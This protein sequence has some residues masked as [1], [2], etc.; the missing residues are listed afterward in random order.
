MPSKRALWIA[1]IG[2]GLVLSGASRMQAGQRHANQ[3]KDQVIVLPDED[4]DFDVNVADLG[5]VDVDPVVVRFG[6]DGGRGYLG[7]RLVDLTPELREYFGTPK[8]AGVLVGSVEADSPAAKAGLKVGDV[9]TA[10]DG[11][12]VESPRDLSRAVRHKKA[13]DVV[14]LDLSRERA[15]KQLS[16]TVADRPVK[17]IQVGDLGPMIHKRLKVLEDGD[18]N[19]KVMPF[20][21]NMGQLQKRLDELEQRMKDLEKKLAK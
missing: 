5:D 1:L 3:D 13:G 12:R 19:T 4:S 16:V 20:R 21:D 9:V 11:E 17:E 8:D 15:K 10:I 2:L 14:K 6:H 18:F 7:V